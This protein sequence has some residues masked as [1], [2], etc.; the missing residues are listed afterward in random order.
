MPSCWDELLD[1]TEDASHIFH[2]FL[3]L[4]SSDVDANT[5]TSEDAPNVE[6]ATLY[7][8]PFVLKQEETQLNEIPSLNMID[9]AAFLAENVSTCV[10][11]TDCGIVTI[12][13]LG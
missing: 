12:F 11:R 5:E 13:F 2:I 9:Q 6:A 10:Q 1:W 8:Q 7:F 3:K 4:Q